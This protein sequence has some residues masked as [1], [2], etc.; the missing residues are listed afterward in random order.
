MKRCF[1]WWVHWKVTRVSFS[2]R[3]FLN[4]GSNG[5]RPGLFFRTPVTVESSVSFTNRGVSKFLFL[6]SDFACHRYH[7][8]RIICITI[9]RDSLST[10][11]SNAQ[12]HWKMCPILSSSWILHCIMTRFHHLIIRSL[13][14]NHCQW[15]L[16]PYVVFFSVRKAPVISAAITSTAFYL[17]YQI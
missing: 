12:A 17:N 15:L 6:R 7:I 2:G 9:G 11:I 4:F 1:F 13:T 8:I 3:K 16:T 14:H 5:K 10:S